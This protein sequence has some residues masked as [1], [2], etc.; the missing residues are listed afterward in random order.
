ML[1]TETAAG[2]AEDLI[3]YAHRLLTQWGLSASP[4]RVARLCRDYHRHAAPRIP[5]EHY[6]LNNADLSALQRFSIRNA[7]GVVDETGETAAHQVD[8]DRG[9]RHV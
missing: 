3:R 2:T 8:R 9:V 7:V 5:F 6:L 1:R 4:S